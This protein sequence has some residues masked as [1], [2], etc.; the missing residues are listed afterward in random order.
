MESRFVI[1]RHCEESFEPQPGKGGFRDECPKCIA[2]R[3]ILPDPLLGLS[4]HQRKTATKLAEK[5]VDGKRAKFLK[6][7]RTF[8]NEPPDF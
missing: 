8:Y 6:T 2:N 3:T 5:V 1:C 7:L 4:D